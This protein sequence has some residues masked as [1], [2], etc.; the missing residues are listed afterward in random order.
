MRLEEYVYRGAEKLRCGYTTG[1]CAAAAAKAAAEMIFTGHEVTGVKLM[2]PKGILLDL[3]VVDAEL[4]EGSASCAIVKDSGDDPDIT[5]GIRVYSRVRLIP[6]GTVIL[7]GEGVGVVTKAGLDRPV[8]DAAI[9]TVPRRMISGAVAE[10]AEK[11]GYSG[12]F[13]VTVS[14]PQG[15]ELAKK[16]FNPRMGIEDGISVI[17]TSGIVEP[18]S[19]TA[20]IETIRTEANIRRAAGQRNMLLTIGNYSEDFVQRELPFSLE[21]SVTCSNFIGDAIDIGMELGFESI[22]IVGHIGKLVKLGAGIMNTHSSWADGRMDVLVT[23][24]VLAGAD[25]ETLK[26]LPDCATADAAMDILDKGGYLE[27]TAEILSQRMD[28]YLR[29][30]VKDSVPIAALAFS[31]KRQLQVRTALAEELIKAIT[32]EENG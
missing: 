12:G 13:E 1:S 27:K 19:N 22:L 31:Y 3:D 28:S 32:E 6:E 9:N 24:G 18:M 30:R 15:V 7:G 4:N 29:A 26:R 8:G 21:R 14:I 23:C 10:I 16:T 20:V 11:Y 2:T 5:N 17:G 25:T